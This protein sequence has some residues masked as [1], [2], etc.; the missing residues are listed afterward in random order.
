MRHGA[1]RGPRIRLRSFR[2]ARFQ[3]VIDG[4]KAFD[5]QFGGRLRCWNT[6]EPQPSLDG[7]RAVVF[8][9]QD[10]LRERFPDCYAES[11]ALASRARDKN[12]EIVNPPEALSNS[13]KSVQARLWQEAGIATPPQFVFNSRAELRDAIRQATFPAILRADRLH[14]QTQMH[15]CESP[16]Q[17]LD[18]GEDAISLPGT[19]SPIIDTREGFR[20]TDPASDW[21]RFYHK[22]RA[23]V[24]GRRV[25]NNHLFFGSDPIV[26]AKSCTFSHY[27]SL[28]PIRRLAGNMA[29]RAHVELDC[30]FAEGPPD[31]E[32]TLVRAAEALDLSFIAIDYSCRANGSLVLWE[33]NPYFSLHDW[34]FPILPR[35]RKLDD[36]LKTFIGA[37]HGYFSELMGIGVEHGRLLHL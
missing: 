10:P 19:L 34:P 2:P 13:I 5:P 32:A 18:L 14:S 6:G 1:G 16:Q 23:F 35:Q 7:V 22:K 25:V 24:F 17:A 36:R 31:D 27:R 4:L 21:A 9:L 3:P 29:C 33:A 28:N 30:A 26:A 20:R 8:L 37:M 12:L 11:A 15:Y